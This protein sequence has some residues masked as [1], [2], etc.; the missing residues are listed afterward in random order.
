MTIHKRK[1]RELIKKW[2]NQDKVTVKGNH[3]IQEDSPEQMGENIS[4]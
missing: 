4:N 1:K 3:F 2:K